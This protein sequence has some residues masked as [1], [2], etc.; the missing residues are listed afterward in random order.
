MDDQSS[1]P[2]ESGYMFVCKKETR[3]RFLPDRYGHCHFCGRPGVVLSE[4]ARR[5]Y[6][7]GGYQAY[8]T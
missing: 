4:F 3:V 2:T 6:G 8:F 1:T 5:G 7:K